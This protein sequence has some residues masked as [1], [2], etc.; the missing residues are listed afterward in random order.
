MKGILLDQNLPVRLRFTPSLPVVHA[1]RFGANPGDSE[2]WRLAREH[3]WAIVTKDADFS[4]RIILAEPPPRVVPL[5]FGNLRLAAF[6]GRLASAWPQVET[7]LATHK[8]INV[9]VDR[10]E[11]VG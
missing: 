8:L 11:A 6:H 3:D 5:R 9:F 2:L 7:L 1:T 10:I 4:V